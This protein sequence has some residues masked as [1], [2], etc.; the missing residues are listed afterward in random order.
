MSD[1]GSLHW[2]PS[3][4]RVDLRQNKLSLSSLIMKLMPIG[5]SLAWVDD[6]N[7]SSQSSTDCRSCNLSR[8]LHTIPAS[9]T[10]DYFNKA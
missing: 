4:T 6:S 9:A 1:A 10:S 3:D 2:F 8:F 7:S 5:A